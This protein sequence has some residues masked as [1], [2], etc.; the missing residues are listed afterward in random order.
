MPGVPG[1][2]LACILCLGDLGH[3]HGNAAADL[4]VVKLVLTGSQSLV[5]FDGVVDAPGVINPV[6]GLD[7]FYSIFSAGKFRVIHFLI[8]HDL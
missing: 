3:P 5:E 2:V 7:N 6:A 8:G 1:E 4:N